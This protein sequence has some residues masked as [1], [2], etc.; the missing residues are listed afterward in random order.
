MKKFILLILMLALPFAG[1]AQRANGKPYRC[2]IQLLQFGE[3]NSH[4]MNV[5][6]DYGQ[7]RKLF[8]TKRNQKLVDEDGKELDFGSM[9]D[10]LNFFG[11][12][13]WEFEAVYTDDYGKEKTKN[14]FLLSKLIFNDEEALEGLMTLAEYKKLKK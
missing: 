11:R 9:V 10:A 1:H 14:R 13:G 2:F 5:I 6:V 12:L 4:D 3:V 7:H 8:S